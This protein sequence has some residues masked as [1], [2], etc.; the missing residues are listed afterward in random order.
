MAYGQIGMI[1]AVSGFFTY[2]IIMTENGFLPVDLFGI[3]R[4][5]DAKGINDLEDSYGQ[6]W[7]RFRF[8]FFYRTGSQKSPTSSPPHSIPHPIPNQIQIWAQLL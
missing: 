8:L 2:F 1:Q 6:Q 5:W 3:R 7:V 4:Q